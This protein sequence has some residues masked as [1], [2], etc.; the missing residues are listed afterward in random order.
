MKLERTREWREVRGFTQRDLAEEAGLGMFT[1]PRIERGENVTP[2]TARKIAA[3]LDLDIMDLMANP[4]VFAGKA[5]APQGLGQIMGVG[6]FEGLVAECIQMIRASK[7]AGTTV[8]N[9][10]LVE[11]VAKAMLRRAR[12]GNHA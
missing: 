11:A 9:D 8:P 10:E 2:R 12:E 4:P 3:A 5:E 1:I 7:P 6:F